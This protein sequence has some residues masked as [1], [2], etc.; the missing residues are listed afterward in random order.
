MLANVP[1]APIT[2]AVDLIHVL[3]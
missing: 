2:D 1:D 3:I